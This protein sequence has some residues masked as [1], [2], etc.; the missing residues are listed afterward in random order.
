MKKML[1]KFRRNEKA[2]AAIEFAIIVPVLAVFLVG[3]A[4]YAIYIG[5]AMSLQQLA[6]QAALY[7]VEGGQESDVEATVIDTS[8]LNTQ[9][10]P[11]TYSGDIVC[12]CA[13][14]ASVQCNGSCGD[15]DFMRSYFSVTVSGN[16]TPVIPYATFTQYF[17]HGSTTDSTITITKTAS[18][19]YQRGQ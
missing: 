8:P 10:S 19:E 16:Y 11:I 15:S 13:N 2:V 17:T 7:V 4:D 9:S 5:K 14:G 18:L 6:D 12:E 3:M 1:Q